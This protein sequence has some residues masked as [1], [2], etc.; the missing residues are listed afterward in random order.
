MATTSQPP[1][2]DHLQEIRQSIDRTAEQ[3]VTSNEP[4]IETEIAEAESTAS[5]SLAILIWLLTLHECATFLRLCPR[6]CS[7]HATYHYA[8]RNP[9]GVREDIWT[10]W[11]L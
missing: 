11:S 4:V 6:T 1:A 8:S 9:Q 2:V 5:E 3:N 7:P 10:K